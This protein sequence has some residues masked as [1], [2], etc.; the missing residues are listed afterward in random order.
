MAV[1][2]IPFVKLANGLSQHPEVWLTETGYDINPESYQKAEAI[3]N[4]TVLQQQA[5]WIIRTSLFYIRYGVKRVFF[6][7]LF[8]DHT[9]G[10]TQYATSGL[11]EGLK[12]RPAADY[13]LQ[14]GK[15]MG[16]YNF[17]KTIHADPLVDVY[18]LG[19]KIM[20][21]LFNRPR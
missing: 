9:G 11:N 1:L 14:T 16:D 10:T 5:D 19:K 18:A 15:L 7:Q 17:V 2:P 3:G 20:Y 21:V 13:I 6:Y 4:K 12:R 8:D